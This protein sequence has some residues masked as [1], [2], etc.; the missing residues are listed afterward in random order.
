MCIYIYI[1]IYVHMCQV[2]Y[3]CTSV[4]YEGKAKSNNRKVLYIT[5]QV[6]ETM[7]YHMI[8][9]PTVM[10]PDLS[11]SCVLLITPPLD[12]VM[13]EITDHAI[14]PTE[15]IVHQEHSSQLSFL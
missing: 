7:Y 6:S 3:I 9:E 10:L 11:C 14:F 8:Q 15:Y 2:I 5:A 12:N 4:I 13:V 1:Y